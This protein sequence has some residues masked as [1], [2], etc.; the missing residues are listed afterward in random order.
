MSVAGVG[1]EDD[2]V[3]FVHAVDVAIA[4]VVS[5]RVCCHF[6][7][8]LVIFLGRCAAIDVVVLLFFDALLI[9]T[10]LSAFAVEFFLVVLLLSL[11]SLVLCDCR[12]RQCRHACIA[13]VVR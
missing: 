5:L 13:S 6:A 3:V 8:D 12:C 7:V 11:L 4:L 1:K 2:G 10:S 9:L